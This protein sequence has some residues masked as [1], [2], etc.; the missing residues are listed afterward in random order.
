MLAC[1]TENNIVVVGKEEVAKGRDMS[2]IRIDRYEAGPEENPE[3]LLQPM[4]CQHCDNA[5]CET[6]CP[7]NATTH[8]PEGLNEQVYNRCVGTRYCNNNC[9]YKVRR[10]NFFNYTGEQTTSPVQ[11]LRANPHVTVRTRGVMEKCSFC[12]QRI[13]T[14]KFAEPDRGE[15]LKDG[16]ITTACQQA[17]PADAI[18]FGDAN[19]KGGQIDRARKSDLAYHVLEEINVRPNV[20]YAA[21][22]RNVH[23]DLDQPVKGGH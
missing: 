9:P 7:V 16:A 10:F 5:P 3:I 2:W 18:V 11:E 13:N 19:I 23:P 22:I 1:Q 21:R 8:S 20:T 4:L 14:A 15:P 6:V 12:I 17:C